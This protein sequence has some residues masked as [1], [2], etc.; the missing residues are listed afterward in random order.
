MG[1]KQVVFFI[2]LLLIILKE[3]MSD[4]F[5]PLYHVFDILEIHVQYFISCLFNFWLNLLMVFFFCF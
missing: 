4:V 3:A 1:L 5:P 2:W